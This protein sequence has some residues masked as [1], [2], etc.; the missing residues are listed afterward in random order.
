[1]MTDMEHCF[2]CLVGCNVYLTP[3]GC[4]GLAPHHDNIEAIVIQVSGRKHWRLYK[5]VEELACS[6]SDDLKQEA[7]GEP[8]MDVVLEAGDVLYFPR[9]V[10]HQAVAQ[11][12]TS[13]HVTLSTFESW[14]YG[15]LIGSCLSEC[16]DR[17]MPTC[18]PLRRGRYSCSHC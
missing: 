6:Y 12:E 11:E 10:V 1:M 17:A 9:G 16:V 3:S 8:I 15:D 5:P 14:S 4:Q 13:V 7:I 2:S 18:L